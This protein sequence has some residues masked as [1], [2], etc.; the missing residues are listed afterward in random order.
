MNH[1]HRAGRQIVGGARADVLLG[2]TVPRARPVGTGTEYLLRLGEEEYRRSLRIGSAVPRARYM[3][4][5][6]YTATLERE[7]GRMASQAADLRARIH[8]LERQLE[9]RRRQI[10]Q[11]ERDTL[12]PIS[13]YVAARQLLDHADAK[14]LASVDTDDLRAALDSPF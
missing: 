10:A 13:G 6:E 11:I 3:T 5:T 9:A 1:P 8:E 14:D 7:L 2:Q 4:P 12:Q